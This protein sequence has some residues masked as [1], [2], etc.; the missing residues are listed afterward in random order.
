MTRVEQDEW[1]LL[2]SM[3]LASRN[4]PYVAFD[5]AELFAESWGAELVDMGGAGHM[6]N[7]SALGLWPEGLI[8]LGA[9][10]AKVGDRVSSV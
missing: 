1:I 6:E 5:R 10:L 4:D 8:H 7:S 9:F 2:P 3:V